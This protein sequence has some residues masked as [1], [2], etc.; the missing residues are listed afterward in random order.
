LN[1]LTAELFKSLID[2][3]GIVHV[4][5]RGAGPA[6][7]DLISGHI[8]MAV[9]AMNG[10]ALELHRAGKLRILAVTNPERLTGAPEIPT[11]VEAGIG[12]MISQN[13]V[14]ILAPAGTPKAIIDQV[15][16][17]TKTCLSERSYQEQLI[18]SGFELPPDSSPERMR[19]FVEGEIARWT[20]V[21]KAVGLKLD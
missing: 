19:S 3:P 2:I 17:A 4:P 10:Q 12:G 21:I 15:A 7:T 13:L 11:A 18:A 20:P 6:I 16:A 5:Y 8:P 1:H 14:G 9:P